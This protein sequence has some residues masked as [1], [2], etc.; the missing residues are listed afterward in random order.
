[1]MNLQY[2]KIPTNILCYILII[3][4]CH[5]SKAIKVL[6]KAY[7]VSAL[8]FFQAQTPKNLWIKFRKNTRL[9]LLP[10]QKQRN[11]MQMHGNFKAQ[12]QISPPRSSCHW[13]IGQELRIFSD[14]NYVSSLQWK[15]KPDR[16]CQ[17]LDRYH[18]HGFDPYIAW[19]WLLLALKEPLTSNPAPSA[20]SEGR[21]ILWAFSSAFQWT[22]AVKQGSK[23]WFRLRSF[24]SIASLWAHL[25]FQMLWHIS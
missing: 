23:S 16:F 18:S 11:K 19:I 13:K 22:P 12:S 1:M 6:T 8:H 7:T 17:V 15:P 9:H 2:Q 4:I 14:M 25:S 3:L 5:I 21:K 24:G 20:L 10:C